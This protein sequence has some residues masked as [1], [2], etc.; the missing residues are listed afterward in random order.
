MRI[1]VYGA[2]RVGAFYGTL[3]ARAGGEVHLVARGAQLE[4]IRSHGIRVDSTLLGH[5][6]VRAP[7]ASA[8][9]ADAGEAGLVLVCVKAH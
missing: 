4:A 2:G 8:R 1:V 6:E 3:L 7:A 5:I 9:A